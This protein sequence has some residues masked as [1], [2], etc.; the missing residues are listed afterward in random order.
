M[1]KSA[2]KYLVSLSVCVALALLS[3]IP[4]Q[5]GQADRSDWMSSLDDTAPLNSLTIPGT[6]DTGALHSIAEISG[7]CQT[8]SVEEQLKIGVRFL[9]IRLQLV[10]NELKIVHSFV[11]QMTDFEDSLTHMVEFI[12]NNKSEFLIISIKEDASAKNSDKNFTD[13]LESM[14]RSYSEISTTQTLPDTVG[15]ARGKIYVAA[16]YKNATIGIPCYDGWVD[17]A[18]F[19]IGDMYVQD[20]YCVSNAEEKIADVHRTYAVSQ[21]QTHTLVLNFTSCYLDTCFPPIYAGL[22]AHDINRDTEKA[23]AEYEE[24]P[25]GVLVCD[26]MTAELADAIIRRNFE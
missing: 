20:N 9:D 25:L 7:K 5:R 22:P 19:E 17:D 2:V 13:V 6:H 10:G 12:R 16:R 23:M 18:A 24:G 1:K 14:L 15:D 26:F 21:K 11:D 3:V 4:L 8:L